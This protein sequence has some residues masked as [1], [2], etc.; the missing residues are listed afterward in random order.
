MSTSPR[1]LSAAETDAWVSLIGV[2]IKVPAA[3]DGELR[4]RVGLAHFELLALSALSEAADRTLPMSELAALSNASLSRLSHVVAKLEQKGWVTRAACP[5]NGRVTNATLT[6]AGFSLV[7]QAAPVHLELART[8]VFDA[9]GPDQVTQLAAIAR[10]IL[11]T[12]DPEASYPPRGTA[13]RP[14]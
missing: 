8:Y 10:Q 12:V 1:W 7:V 2:L 3:L 6:D 9:L 13:I 4:R 5:G 14:A 11:A